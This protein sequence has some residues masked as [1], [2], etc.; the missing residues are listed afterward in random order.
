MNSQDIRNRIAEMSSHVLFTYQ[1]VKGGVDPISSE[2]FEIWFG[3]ASDV[4]TS[5]DAVMQLPIF[6]GLSLNAITEDI[7][8]DDE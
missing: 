4:A 6:N 8:F 3:D 7:I 2:Y 1:G 5:L